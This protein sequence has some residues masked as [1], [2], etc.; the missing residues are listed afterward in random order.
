M[1]KPEATF[2][3]KFINPYVVVSGK[4]FRLNNHDPGDTHHLS[5]EDKPEA[6]KLLAEGVKMLTRTL[7]SRSPTV[8]C[9]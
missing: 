6:K 5:S 7:S 4:E 2:F 9:C 3:R 1:P 8:G